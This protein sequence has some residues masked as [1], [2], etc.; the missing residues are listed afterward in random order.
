[1]S[2]NICVNYIIILYYI[3]TITVH[4]QTTH[5]MYLFN[6][7]ILLLNSQV[8]YKS[9]A[10]SES[11]SSILFATID[12]MDYAD[13]ADYRDDNLSMPPPIEDDNVNS[14]IN[15]NSANSNKYKKLNG[16]DQRYDN[17]IEEFINHKLLI[18]KIDGFFTNK[19]LLD[20]LLKLIKERTETRLEE[21]S[22]KNTL[23]Y[24]EYDSDIFHQISQYNNDNR[25]K[26]E[27]TYDIFAG[28]L[29]ND[30]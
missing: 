12:D 27:L 29:L 1:M 10:R 18:N 21:G 19:K 2:I 13:Y 23:L 20:R 30:W 6:V 26:S 4:H 5:M 25:N 14:F 7:V 24:H 17:T 16:Y 15:I 3:I 8:Q 28:G 11:R 22:K 9:L